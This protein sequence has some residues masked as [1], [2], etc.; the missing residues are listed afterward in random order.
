MYVYI[1]T[2]HIIISNEQ[3][4]CCNHVTLMGVHNMFGV[5]GSTVRIT[6]H[7]LY[8]IYLAYLSLLLLKDNCCTFLFVVY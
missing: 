1:E 3:G 2:L 5:T 6:I 4:R 7:S 8:I